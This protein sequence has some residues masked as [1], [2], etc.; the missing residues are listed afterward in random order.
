MVSNTMISHNIN[1]PSLL[2]QSMIDN[3]QMF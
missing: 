2:L 1:K 3:K